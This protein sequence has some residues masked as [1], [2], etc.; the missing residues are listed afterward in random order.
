[1][2]EAELPRAL[3]SCKCE[4]NEEGPKVMSA[5]KDKQGQLAQSKRCGSKVK[6]RSTAACVGLQKGKT[7]GRDGWCI[8]DLVTK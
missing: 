1:M 2:P 4:G 7:E 6:G 3:P 8:S 5:L